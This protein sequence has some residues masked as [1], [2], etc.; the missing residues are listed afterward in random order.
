[1]SLGVASSVKMENT[2]IKA[3]AKPVDSSVVASKPS[4]VDSSKES[5]AES[6]KLST[7]A[8]DVKGQ[9][10][11]TSVTTKEVFS[12]SSVTKSLGAQSVIAGKSEAPIQPSAKLSDTSTRITVKD[13]SA[14]TETPRP[15]TKESDAS[16]VSRVSDS[17]ASGTSTELTKVAGITSASKTEAISTSKAVDQ[18]GIASAAVVGSGKNL[19]A[20]RSTATSAVSKSKPTPT[21]ADGKWSCAL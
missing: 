18:S 21:V 14:P 12:E 8:T 10:D 19:D 4:T 20:P 3:T 15:L 17:K 1:M 16:K 5:T 7:K 6:L 9:Q 2:S 11:V 13:N